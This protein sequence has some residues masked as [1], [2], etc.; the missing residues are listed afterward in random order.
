M[1]TETEASIERTK[2]DV[3][4]QDK[5][6]R[7]ETVIERQELGGL[8]IDLFTTVVYSVATHLYCVYLLLLSHHRIVL[9]REHWCLWSTPS[10]LL[11]KLETMLVCVFVTV[12]QKQRRIQ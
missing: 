10:K 8:L 11:S 6:E 5:N 9:D 7:E 1:K 2:V 3:A 12:W 4:Q